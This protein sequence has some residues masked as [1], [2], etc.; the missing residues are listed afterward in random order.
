MVA[1]DQSIPIG[2]PSRRH[3]SP[4][5]PEAA[6]HARAESQQQRDE[7]AQGQPVRVAVLRGVAGVSDL[8]ARDAEEDHVD[9]PDDERDEGGEAGEEGHEDGARAVVREAAEAEE[10]REAREAR[11]DGVEDEGEGEVVEGGGG[12]Q[13]VAGG[14]GTSGLVGT[15]EGLGRRKS[16]PEAE[17]RRAEAIADSDFGARVSQAPEFDA[18]TAVDGCV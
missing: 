11:G 3:G 12:C 1:I 9:D 6:T 13:R 14:Q 2:R 17:D 10:R 15:R 5:S 4:I 18:G 7:R 8:V 16:V